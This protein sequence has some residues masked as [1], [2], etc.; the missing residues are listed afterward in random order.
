MIFV[1]SHAFAKEVDQNLTTE[2]MIGLENTLIEN[3]EAGDVIPG[4]E[5]LRKIRVASGG[6]GKR[7]GSR[8]IYYWYV[9]PEKIQFCRIYK[10]SS[11][12]NISTAELKKIK[13]ELE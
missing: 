13:A 10:K 5:G 12:S 1:D 9:I 11:Q 7:G 2:E 8:V 4:A 3:P 6:K